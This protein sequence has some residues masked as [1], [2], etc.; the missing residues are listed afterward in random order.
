MSGVQPKDPIVLHRYQGNQT[1][2]GGRWYKTGTS[3][4]E[5]A[6]EQHSEALL[7]R[8]PCEVSDADID[9]AAALLGL[10]PTTRCWQKTQASWDSLTMD[11]W[12]AGQSPEADVRRPPIEFSKTVM[13][14]LYKK[15]EEQLRTPFP[16]MLRPKTDA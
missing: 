7:Q 11:N 3:P 13:D 8:P 12:M 10:P 6:A 5:V 14:V 4:C 16:H 15:M 2:C 9:V 1:F